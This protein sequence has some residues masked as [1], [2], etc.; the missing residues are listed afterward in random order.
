M[1]EVGLWGD[2]LADL[3]QGNEGIPIYMNTSNLNSFHIIVFIYQYLPLDLPISLSTSKIQLRFTR[4]I[5]IIY[6]FILNNE[7]SEYGAHDWK[8]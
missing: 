3:N 1:I 4:I 5:Q 2:E 7:Y 8:S 6:L